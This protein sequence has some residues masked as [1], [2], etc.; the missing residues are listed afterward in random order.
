MTRQIQTIVMPSPGLPEARRIFA[1]GDVHGRLD[2]LDDLLGQIFALT[3]E[4]PMDDQIVFLGDY[5]DRGNK[6]AEVISRLIELEQGRF[7]V[8]YLKGN[9]EDMMYR[10]LA[11]DNASQ[12]INWIANGGG[13]T[14]K[15]YGAQVPVDYYDYD[16]VAAYRDDILDT[17]PDEHLNFLGR[18]RLYHEVSPYLFVHA[19]ISPGKAIAEQEEYDLLWMREPFLSSKK[20][21]GSIVVHGHTSV[22]EPKTLTN[23]I[24][25]DTGAVG[26]YLTSAVFTSNTVEFITSNSCESP[27]REF[28]QPEYGRD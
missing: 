8:I 3:H 23:R 20:D 5:V 26:G 28:K 21:F 7:P 13:A 14:I 22:K 15:S 25:L 4:N 24:A 19:G 12:G 27:D 18:L 11:D 10:Y 17:V 16:E 1:I 6:S 2:D 9:H